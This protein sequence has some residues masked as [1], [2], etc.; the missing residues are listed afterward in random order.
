MTL[1]TAFDNLRGVAQSRINAPITQVP[2]VSSA[3]FDWRNYKFVTEQIR[4]GYM[5]YFKGANGGVEMV[6]ATCYPQLHIAYPVFHFNVMAL[7]GIVTGVFCDVTPTPY[8][9]TDLRNMLHAYSRYYKACN[10]KSPE[11]TG[12][13]SDQYLALSPGDNLS[14]IISTCLNLFEK[15]LCFIL[16]NP[17]MLSKSKLLAHKVPQNKYSKFQQ[18]NIKTL[19]AHTALTTY[20]GKSKATKFIEEMLFP[21]ID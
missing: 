3:Q 14:D 8:D 19:A 15:Y 9:N 10:R 18:Q 7:D 21:V 5:G 4:H 2:S 6:H 1:L 17:V 20:I 16:C 12:F 11:W 13:F